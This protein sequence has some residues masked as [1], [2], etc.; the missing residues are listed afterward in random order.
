MPDPATRRPRGIRPAWVDAAISALNGAVGDALH[1][2]GNLEPDALTAAL[3]AP[4]EK[5][6]I[7]VHGR[8]GR[9]AGPVPSAY[10]ESRRP[11]RHV[12]CAARNRTLVAGGAHN[13]FAYSPAV[14]GESRRRYESTGSEQEESA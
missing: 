9:R 6:C 11:A 13:P 2:R 1:A 8:P 3:P 7:R 12:P 4:T 5:L 14:Y 10:G